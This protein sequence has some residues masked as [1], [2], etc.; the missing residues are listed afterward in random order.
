M[1]NPPAPFIFAGDYRGRAGRD[2]SNVLPTDEAIAEAIQLGRLTPAALA[3]LIDQLP[4]NTLFDN[5][6][7]PDGPGPVD[8]DGDQAPTGH[9]YRTP[10]LAS[11]AREGG[12]VTFDPPP[13][14]TAMVEAALEKNVFSHSATVRWTADDGN[15]SN[16]VLLN[17]GQ[18]AGNASFQLAVYLT[19]GTD[20]TFGSG[21]GWV[22]FMVFDLPS[23]ADA[24]YISLGKSTDPGPQGGDLLFAPQLDV[25]YTQKYRYYGSDTV[26]VT[27]IDGTTRTFTDSRLAACRGLFAAAQGRCD[28]GTDPNIEMISQTAASLPAAPQPHPGAG[29]VFN[30]T[31]WNWLQTIQPLLTSPDLDITYAVSDFFPGHADKYL[32]V[33]GD[34]GNRAWWAGHTGTGGQQLGIS[35]AGTAATLTSGTD[36][37][38]AGKTICRATRVAATGVATWMATTDAFRRALST[39]PAWADFATDTDLTGVLDTSTEALK[40]GVPIGNEDWLIG[41]IRYICVRDGIDGP[42]VAERDFIDPDNVATPVDSAGNTWQDLGEASTWEKVT[43]IMPAPAAS[44]VIEYTAGANQELILTADMETIEGDLVGAGGGSGSG[45]RGAAGTHRTCGASGP[46]GAHTPFT[47]NVPALIA[48]G[49]TAVYWDVGTGGLAGA[50]V[51]ANTTPGNPGTAG[52]ATR[53]KT[54]TSAATAA[55]TLFSA[56]GGGAGA[57]GIL[58]AAD[59]TNVA[60]TGGAQGMFPGGA[61]RGSA[62]STGQAPVVPVAAPCGGGGGGSIDHTNA[63]GNGADGGPAPGSLSSITAAG[64]VAPGGNGADGAQPLDGAALWGGSGAGGAA[65]STTAAGKGGKGGRGAGAGGGGASLNG[66]ASGPGETGGDGFVRLRITYHAD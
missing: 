46:G 50:A 15:N 56:N 39:D 12:A 38:P 45:A 47:L 66:F 49:V 65:S 51:T 17:Y 23:P 10:R 34:D 61:G 30:G 18:A 57:G 41:T 20:G 60:A 52:G 63:V 55:N 44:S 3:D 54:N 36:H 5:F 7:R 27:L 62:A 31:P 43:A 11:V 21:L 6:D 37:M 8:M 1:T 40:V 9:V 29:K 13:G 33:Y 53:V 24:D 4:F 58:D 35:V 25:D 28:S 42:I 22:A 19:P 48:D 64:G 59:A 32:S 2:G 16:F 14:Q 26:K